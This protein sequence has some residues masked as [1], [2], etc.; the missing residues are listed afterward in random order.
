MEITPEQ[1][2]Q[3]DAIIATMET[4]VIG[5]LVKSQQF[6]FDLMEAAALS[7]IAKFEARSKKH[8][9][10]V[11]KVQNNKIIIDSAWGDRR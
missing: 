7:A 1:Q 4:A 10:E 8:A 9:E 11:A 5:G 6:L 2:A 3:A